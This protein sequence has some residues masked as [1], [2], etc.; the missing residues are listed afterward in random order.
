MQGAGPTKDEFVMT[1][2]KKAWKTVNKKVIWLVIWSVYQLILIQI[3]SSNYLK[4][5]N[6]QNKRRVEARK[7][8]STL[9]IQKMLK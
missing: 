7:W 4:E 8:T 9:K 1:M 6:M 5:W 3:N 2:M